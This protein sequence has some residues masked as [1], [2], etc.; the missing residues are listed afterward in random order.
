MKISK[1]LKV[2]GSISVVIILAT[3]VCLFQLNGSISAEREAKLRQNE[4]DQLA[5]S[6][7]SASDYLTDRARLYVHAGEKVYY[8]DYWREVNETRTREKALERLTELGVGEEQLELMRKANDISQGLVLVEERAMKE[9][10]NKDFFVARGLMFD[11]YYNSTKEQISDYIGRFIDSVNDIANEEAAKAQEKAQLQM[12]IVYIMGFL[13]VAVILLTFLLLAAKIKKLSLITDRLNQLATNDGDLTS[14]VDIQSKDEIG[15]IASS[16]NTFVEKVQIIVREV[17][18]SVEAVSSSSE[19]LVA[20]T[21]Q[22]STASDEVAKVIEEIAKGAS[23][24]AEDTAAGAQSAVDLGLLIEE[25]I[26]LIQD[27]GNE[28]QNVKELVTQGFSTI[29]LLNQISLENEQVTEKVY[30]T[31]QETNERALKI[32]EASEMIMNIAD[33]TNLLALNAA[34]EAARA[35]D[36]GRGF[37]VVAD[38]IRK[39]AEESTNFADNINDIIMDLK[40]KM[41]DAVEAMEKAK[42]IVKKQ[43]DSV[44]HTESMFSGISDSVETMGVSISQLEKSADSMNQKKEE[45]LSTISNLSAISEENAAGTQEASASVEEQTASLLEIVKASENLSRQAEEIQTNINR[46]KY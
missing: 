13:V 18:E 36:A 28:S 37:S 29:G 32:R 21:A 40:V 45:V 23:D 30:E 12:G 1:L 33:Q 34:I 20:T 11:S 8:D 31:V 4:I 2:M 44:T 19:E 15:M 14:R 3:L 41:S 38:E 10:E 25:E 42:Q 9:V 16:F 6:L 39:L 35:G 17:S 22:V 7:Q 26:T 27:I 5:K 46:F 43:S 24:Q